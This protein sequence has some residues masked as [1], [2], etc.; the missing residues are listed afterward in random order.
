MTKFLMYGLHSG[1]F[2][3]ITTV[4]NV[5]FVAAWKH[6][7]VYAGMTYSKF[8]LSTLTNPPI[9]AVTMIIWR[10][11]IPRTWTLLTYTLAIFS[12]R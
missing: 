6:N 8:W 5:V 4:I 2:I 11:E 7:L 3:V 10:S 12:P 9:G 1:A